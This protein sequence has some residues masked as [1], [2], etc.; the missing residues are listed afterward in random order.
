MVLGIPVEIKYH[1]VS[2]LPSKDIINFLSTCRNLS[3]LLKE[4][5]LW[6]NLAR[7]D[8]GDST[9][10]PNGESWKDKYKRLCHSI[11]MEIPR[12]IE[13]GS[14]AVIFLKSKILKNAV[15]AVPDETVSKG[16]LVVRA[17]AF[18]SKPQRSD[19]YVTAELYA[20]ETGCLEWSRLHKCCDK[21]EPG[22][23]IKFRSYGFQFDN[24]GNASISTVFNAT[25]THS[26]RK[27]GTVFGLNIII[28]FVG[29]KGLLSFS[30]GIHPLTWKGGKKKSKEDEPNKR[31]RVE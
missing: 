30:T 2:Y 9:N 28:H 14:S 23:P 19:G 17:N 26:R 18:S 3:P 12:K 16:N 10:P 24:E 8:F 6:M 5:F 15:V 29:R 21:C 11:Q 7:R 4:E 25:P 1:I 13:G 27:R 22:C 31:Q 20:K